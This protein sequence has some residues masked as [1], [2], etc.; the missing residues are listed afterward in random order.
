MSTKI[1]A[2]CDALGNLLKFALMPGQR[3]DSKGVEEMIRNPKFE[4]L[5]ADKAFDVQWLIERLQA[6]GVPIVIS[7]RSNRRRPL[8]ID[9]HRCRWS[10]LNSLASLGQNLAQAFAI[11]FTEALKSPG[12]KHEAKRSFR[13]NA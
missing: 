4:A 9:E 2:L 5:L 12:K 10:H 3:H 11:A 13:K 6:Q 7:Q 8:A 1:L